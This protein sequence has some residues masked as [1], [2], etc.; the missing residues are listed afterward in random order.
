MPVLLKE[1]WMHL[2]CWVFMHKMHKFWQDFF[3]IDGESI[4]E[5]LDDL[6]WETW[7]INLRDIICYIQIKNMFGIESIETSTPW[8]YI[9]LISA[10]HNF[11]INLWLLPKHRI[12]SSTDNCWANQWQCRNEDIPEKDWGKNFRR[13]ILNGCLNEYAM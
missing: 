3:P 13:A 9:H 7:N 4:L 6:Y 12:W 5:V 10:E 11:T 8:K 1:T 2:P